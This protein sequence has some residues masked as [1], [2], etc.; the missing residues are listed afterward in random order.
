MHIFNG[1]GMIIDRFDLDSGPMVLVIL[2]IDPVIGL[3]SKT[4]LPILFQL[5]SVLVGFF[6][7]LTAFLDP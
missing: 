2:E 7:I 4:K 1:N 5:L 6:E 3:Q